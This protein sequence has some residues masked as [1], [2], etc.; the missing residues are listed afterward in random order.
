MT[1]GRDFNKL[2]DIFLIQNY[3][4]YFSFLANIRLDARRPSIVNSNEMLPNT[5][6]QNPSTPPHHTTVINI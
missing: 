4:I 3:E 2:I 1:P 6:D 5:E